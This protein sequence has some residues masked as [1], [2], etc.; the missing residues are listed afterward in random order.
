MS[1]LQDLDRE[2]GAIGCSE[3]G[4][5][6]QFGRDVAVDQQDR[7]AVVVDVEQLWRQRVATVVALALLGIEVDSHS[8]I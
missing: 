5:L 3:T 1:A 2:L 6:L 7:L 8:D 4:L